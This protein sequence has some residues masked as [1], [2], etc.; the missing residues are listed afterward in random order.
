VRV[1]VEYWV[2]RGAE[3]LCVL[4]SHRDALLVARATGGRV[5]I[6]TYTRA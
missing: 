3:R 5:E 2:W 6:L 1:R 4:T